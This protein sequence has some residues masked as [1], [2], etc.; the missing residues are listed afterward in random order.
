MNILQLTKKFP[1]P[2]KDGEAWAVLGL[3]NGLKSEGCSI[4]LLSITEPAWSEGRLSAL[5]RMDIYRELNY[6]P[7]DTSPKIFSALYNLFTSKSY[8]AV[9]F[10]HSEF[11]LLLEEILTKNKYDLIICESVYMLLY[12]DEIRRVRPDCKILARTHNAEHLIWQRYGQ[13]KSWPKNQY[14]TNQS[15]RLKDFEMAKLNEADGILAISEQD[16]NVFRSNGVRTRAVLCPIGMTT[17]DSLPRQRENKPLIIGFIGSLNWRPNLEGLKWFL[18]NCWEDIQM[19]DFESVLMIA[20]KNFSGRK[21]WNN[22]PHVTYLGEIDDSDSFLQ[23]VDVLIVPLL[24]GSGTRVKILQAFRNLTPVLSTKLGAEG[25]DI[26][27]GTHAFIED[28]SK[29]WVTALDKIDAGWNI[30]E[31]TD[32]ALSYFTDIHDPFKIAERV[33]LFAREL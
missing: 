28:E 22:K 23:Q 9:R 4:D 6:V 8:H 13:Q 17:N 2:L 24:S 11:G 10:A 14:F 21:F 12:V 3:A 26:K 33:M 18:E 31:M 1:F 25:L 15:Q 5:K 19:E 32:T 29:A 7:L 27:N 20:G 30:N 16:L